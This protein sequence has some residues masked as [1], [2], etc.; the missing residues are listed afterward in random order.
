MWMNRLLKV[1]NTEFSGLKYIVF[2]FASISLLQCKPAGESH[3]VHDSSRQR[4]PLNEG[5]Y[6]MKYTENPDSFLYDTR[7]EI[8][9]QQENT[10]ADAKPTEASNVTTS[11]EVLKAY[12]LPTANSFIKDPA[13]HHVRPDGSPG[14]DFPFVQSAFDEREWQLVD[15]PHDWAITGPFMDGP[16]PEV[17]GGMGRLPSHGVGWY[18]KKINIEEVDQ[19]KNIYLDIDG[20][21]SYTMVW[22]NGQ[23][24][25]G[26]PYGYNS[27]RIDL[28]PFIK[29]GENQIAIR[30][31][32]PNY[33][34][35]WYPGGGIYRNVWLTKT[36][37]VHV[38]HWG[39]YVT[40]SDVTNTSASISVE[41]TIVNN[42]EH[43]VDIQV[44]TLI[45]SLDEKGSRATM[46]VASIPEMNSTILP[47][48]NSTA[49]GTVLLSNPK[50]WG[51]PQHK[52]LTC[53]LRL[54][55]LK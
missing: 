8:I 10:V 15:L 11:D 33:S 13:Q 25:G 6:F 1:N 44:A 40:T 5:W 23:L 31:D 2:F 9:N 7:P 55:Q 20:A 53:M 26:W 35:R 47:G 52:C 39:S 37:R 22:I 18:R 42:E 43:D 4:I 45:Y 32:N 34:A 46:A 50:L 48:A 16:N 41:T 49:K 3:E 19:S 24:A 38:A 17:G 14:K 54:L 36:N 29:A 51:P 21:M 28:T 30:L 27:F 12:I